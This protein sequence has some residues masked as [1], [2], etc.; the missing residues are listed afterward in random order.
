MK[1]QINEIRRM[2]QLAGV[3]KESQQLNEDIHDDIDQDLMNG[4]FDQE[5]QIEYLKDVI[6][7]CQSKINEIESNLDESQLSEN[8]NGYKDFMNKN[9]PGFK[10]EGEQSF[11]EFVNLV[12]KN[13]FTAGVNDP[14]MAQVNDWDTLFEYWENFGDLSLYTQSDIIQLAK[15]ANVSQDNI[16]YILDLPQVS[17]LERG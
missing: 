10:P 4:D 7:Y 13:I 15:Q 16:D 6:S 9:Y 2:Q 8:E 11:V 14:T 5:G 3:I 17:S 1:K 12:A